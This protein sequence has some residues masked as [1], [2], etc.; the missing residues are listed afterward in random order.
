MLIMNGWWLQN[1][2]DNSTKQLLYYAKWWK[3]DEKDI[4]ENTKTYNDNSDQW[5]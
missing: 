4:S 2:N 1:N 5:L 3:Y